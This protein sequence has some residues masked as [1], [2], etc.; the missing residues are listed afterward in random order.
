MTRCSHKRG[1]GTAL[2]DIW[3]KRLLVQAPSPGKRTIVHSA[4]L[5]MAV[6]PTAGTHR[7]PSF[8]PEE[9]GEARNSG[10]ARRHTL[11]LCGKSFSC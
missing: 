4:H 6:N 2:P 11:S 5:H 1:R 3:A 9:D 7:L 8:I 10:K